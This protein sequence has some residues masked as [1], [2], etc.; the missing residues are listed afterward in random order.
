[1]SEIYK[2]FVSEEENLDF[3]EEAMFES[4]LYESRGIGDFKQCLFSSSPKRP[5][6]YIVG[7]HW[8]DV[9]VKMWNED[10]KTGIL[11][12]EELYGQFP[13]WWLDRVLPQKQVEKYKWLLQ[14]KEKIDG[15]CSV[16]CE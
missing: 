11:Y 12:V 4:Y 7:K 16:V 3:S 1:M 10:I 14:L 8:M 2:L 5:N 15:K 13:N 9:T 6:G